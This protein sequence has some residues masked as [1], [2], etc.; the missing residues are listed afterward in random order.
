MA[1]LKRAGDTRDE[2]NGKRTKVKSGAVPTKSGA[3]VK[4]GNAKVVPKKEFVKA[5]KSDAKNGNGKNK[6]KVVEE[7]ED[8]ESIEYLQSLG[9]KYLGTVLNLVEER[10]V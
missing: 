8:A 6:K 4:K 9:D 3:P 5:G 2:R 1:G 10:N 7:E